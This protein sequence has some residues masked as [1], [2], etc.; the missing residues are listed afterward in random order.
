MGKAGPHFVAR[1]SKWRTARVPGKGKPALWG[2]RAVRLAAICMGK[3]CESN[4]PWAVPEESRHARAGQER[5]RRRQRVARVEPVRLSKRRFPRDAFAVCFLWPDRHVARP[6]L[7]FQ[8]SH[9]VSRSPTND[10]NQPKP[11]PILSRILV[12]SDMT[13]L[14]GGQQFSTSEQKKLNLVCTKIL[15]RLQSILDDAFWWLKDWFFFPDLAT[16]NSKNATFANIRL[17]RWI[18]L[19]STQNVDKYKHD[20]SMCLLKKCS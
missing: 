4:F 8:A 15:W 3:I 7:T 10:K 6:L 13:I 1:Q 12:R 2:G 20:T 14:G 16:K 5:T 19:W 11:E 18:F 9:T 17:I